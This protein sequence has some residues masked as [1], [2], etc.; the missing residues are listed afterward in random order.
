MVLWI[1]GSTLVAL[2]AG[3]LSWGAYEHPPSVDL[4]APPS[5]ASVVI[6]RVALVEPGRPDH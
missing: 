2:V 1:L 4:V 6:E 3:V 5:E